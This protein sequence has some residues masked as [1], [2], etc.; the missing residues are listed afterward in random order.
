MWLGVVQRGEPAPAF[1]QAVL[2]TDNP[3]LIAREAA[4]VYNHSA[5]DDGG[6]AFIGTTTLPLFCLNCFRSGR[7]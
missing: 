7:G 4:N 1:G 6:L 3:M 5:S 2:F